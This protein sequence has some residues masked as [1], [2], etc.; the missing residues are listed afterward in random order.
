ME[1]I[2]HDW[3]K[4]WSLHEGHRNALTDGNTQETLTYAELFAR[5]Q[6]GAHFL[7]QHCNIKRGDRV[8]YIG[9]NDISV[10]ALFFAIS[11]IGAILVPV[12]YRLTSTEISY[13]LA[14]S[15][16]NLI[17]H[18]DEFAQLAESG[19]SL[20]SHGCQLLS[21]NRFSE[22][23]L[24]NI[25]YPRFQSN[26]EDPVLIIYT[27]GTTGQPKGAMISYGALFWNAVSTSLRL[28]ITQED[29]AVTFLP[30]FHTGGWN[31]LTTPFF[32]RGAHI[33]LT[34][35]FDGQQI[36]DLSEKYFATLIFGVPTTMSLMA[37]T[38]QFEKANLKSVRYA[39]VGGEPMPLEHIQK[40]HDKGILIRQGYGLT[41]FGPNVFSLS[42][43]DALNKMGSIGFPNSYIDVRVITENGS[44][45][46]PHQVGEL[47]LRG[48]ACM[49][50][51]WKNPEATKQAMEYGWLK[52]G[53]LV[54]FDNEGY[55]YVVGRKKDMY[56]SGGENV[57]PAE[58]E[59]VIS[60]VS[61]VREV[62]VIGQPDERWGESGVAFISSERENFDIEQLREH[63]TRHLAKFKIPKTFHWLKELPKSG[64]GKIL[65]KDLRTMQ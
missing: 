32:F 33:I 37:Q 25:S 3:L 16:A 8:V 18:D 57:Y 49:L 51:Y 48:P 64:A 2:Q 54:Q 22:A 58:V 4:I 45:A 34:N 61:W 24:K 9:Q 20:V 56:K 43:R 62:A 59:S 23:S 15:E 40:W 35:K 12:N 19:C 5:S 28:N 27:S 41:E 44:E 29:C 13:I 11:R 7:E 60:Q 47:W 31:V 36:L 1:T 21:L 65:K 53:D 52:T 46:E 30:L 17:I 42:E 38:A 26:S 10:I 50:G 6:A 14:N 39:I 63:C 55:F